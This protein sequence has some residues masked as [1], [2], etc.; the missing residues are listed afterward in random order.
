[1]VIR[2]VI[3]VKSTIGYT[4]TRILDM[5]FRC[6]IICVSA[7]MANNFTFAFVGNRR[8]FFIVWNFFDFFIVV[9]G[10][11]PFRVS[12]RNRFSIF[13]YILINRRDR[14]QNRSQLHS[15]NIMTLYNC[16]RILTCDETFHIFL[17][18]INLTLPYKMF[19]KN[20]WKSISQINNICQKI[21]IHK[22][23]LT[24]YKSL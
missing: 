23:P 22:R 7:A 21:F 15:S 19:C 2:K 1:M 16:D 20:R 13:S 24:I 3:I 11:L 5:A 10:P 8:I 9:F 4:Y 6:I 18:S 14:V 12:F 17:C